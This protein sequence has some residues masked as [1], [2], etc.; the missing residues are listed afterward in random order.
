[1]CKQIHDVTKIHIFNEDGNRS[2]S[3]SISNDWLET[4]IYFLFVYFYSESDKLYN[5]DKSDCLHVMMYS[6]FSYCFAF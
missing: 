4:L 6:Y 2:F 1:M 3:D 5:C